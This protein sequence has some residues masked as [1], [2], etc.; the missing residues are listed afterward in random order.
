MSP[1]SNPLP[2]AVKDLAYHI[3]FQIQGQKSNHSHIHGAA[4]LTLG[5]VVA[6]LDSNGRICLIPII[7][8]TGKKGGFRSLDAVPIEIKTSLGQNDELRADIRFNDDGT[9]LYAITHSGAVEITIREFADPSPM[10]LALRRR[11]SQPPLRDERLPSVA[12]SGFSIEF[13]ESINSFP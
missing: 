13:P 1:L 6:F 7:D 11:Q 4:I 9:K 5:N 10:E 12:E 8:E 3:F 2:D